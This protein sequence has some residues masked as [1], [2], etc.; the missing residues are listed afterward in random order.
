M[1]A[2]EERRATGGRDVE[3]ERRLVPQNGGRQDRSQY[4]DNANVSSR[5][6]AVLTRSAPWPNA[7]DGTRGHGQNL[8]HNS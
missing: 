6:I 7:R 1:L 4:L 5:F 8:A 3:F 2:A